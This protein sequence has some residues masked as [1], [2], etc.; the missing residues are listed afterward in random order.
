[1][2]YVG[3]D[4][5]KR[6]HVACAIDGDGR[7]LAGP[8]EFENSTPGFAR[9]DSFLEGLGEAG[10]VAVGMEATSHY[11]LPLFCHLAGAGR[12]AAV[13]NPIR[14]DAMRRFTNL[15]KVKTDAVDC[16][17]IA[18]ALRAGGFEPSR[19]ADER[20]ASLRE[21]T[22]FQLAVVESAA[23]LKER[24]IDALDQVFPEY[25][26]LFSDV[27]GE[28]SREFLKRCPTPEE[29]ERID[30]RTLTRL[31]ERASRGRMGRDKARE[32]KRAARG[33][34]G[35]SLAASSL[36]LEIRLLVE[37]LEFV[38]GQI[39]E[40]D[41]EI[42]ALL[43]EVEPLILTIPG[44]GRRT[45]AAI[46]AEIGDVR[47]FKSAASLVKYAGI[48]PAKNQSGGF[49]AEG[50]HITKQGSPY[51]RRA[52]YLAAQAQLLVGGP[53]KPYYDKK[54]S[55]GKAHR[56]AVIAVARKLTH[57]IYAVLSKQEPFDAELYMRNSPSS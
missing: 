20:V 4:I 36:S 54:R 47:R 39:D 14:T 31:L 49:D 24:V 46:V 10:E 41:S 18:D 44:V 35:A 45:G 1:M 5:A 43:E 12:E 26:S 57:L 42:A 8:M 11:W 23:R 25:P 38:E 55:E 6:S 30:A 2:V 56:E 32:L 9:L 27:F 51:L 3:I 53:L 33:T 17:V 37:Q 22:R 34:C 50:V 19:L 48:C 21:L 16:A 13:I 52:L 15:G 29:C 7:R 40:L 28:T